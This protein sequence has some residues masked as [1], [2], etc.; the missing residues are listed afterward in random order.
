MSAGPRGRPLRRVAQF[1]VLCI[2]CTGVPAVGAAQ[3]SA[4]PQRSDPNALLA[5]ARD[6]LDAAE[7][8]GAP[9]SPDATVWALAIAAAERA[10]AA[11]DAAAEQAADDPDDPAADTLRGEALAVLARAYQGAGWWVRA[12][13]AWERRIEAAGRLAGDDLADWRDAV[14]QLAYARYQAGDL[15][16]AAERFASVLEVVPADA[17]ALRWSGRIALERD[18]PEAAIRFWTSLV[19]QA[20]DDAG[21]RYYLELAV[22]RRD[23]GRVASDAYREGLRLLEADEIDAALQAFTR[24]EQ[25]DPSWVDPLRW[26]ARTLLDSGRSGAVAAWARVVEARPDDADAA[27]FLER[28]RLQARVGREAVVAADA[29]RAAL[30]RNDPAAAVAAWVRAVEAAPTWTEAQLGL[31]RAATTVGSVALAEEAWN[32]LLATLPEGDPIRAEARQGLATVRLLDRLAPEVAAEYVAAERAFELGDVA[33]AVAALERVVAAAP[34][35]V[36]AWAFLGR[37]AFARADWSTAARA[38]ERASELDPNDADLAFFAREARALA[39]PDP[40]A[41][42]ER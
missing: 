12:V 11:S 21:A 22:E 31:A 17:E 2:A 23:H 37:I 5:E 16:A 4:A 42:E 29:A 19:G 18:D 33:A 6:R 41:P 8:S 34:D 9:A 27:W 24:A 39:G 14:V 20:P 15:D 10:V 1:L 38:Y 25:A 32:E 35:T 40:D 13:D 26:R 30:A 3:E 36:E 28:A 7:R